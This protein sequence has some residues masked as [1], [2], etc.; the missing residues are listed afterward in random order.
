MGLDSVLI[1]RL[2]ILPKLREVRKNALIVE[3]V[4]LWE[5]RRVLEAASMATLLVSAEV[6]TLERS[7]NNPEFKN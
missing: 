1:I 4:P 3:G 2:D 6:D 5:Y 7:I